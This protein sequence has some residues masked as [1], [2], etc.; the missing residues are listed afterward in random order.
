MSSKQKLS[1]MYNS[2]TNATVLNINFYFINTNTL[3]GSYI[4]IFLS[5]NKAGFIHMF[6]C[7]LVLA[8]MQSIIER[9]HSYV[10]I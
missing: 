6:I 9:I 8:S 5:K 1:Y 3:Q 2:V 4:F 7:L 10:S